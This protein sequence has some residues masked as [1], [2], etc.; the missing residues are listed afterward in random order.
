MKATEKSGISNIEAPKAGADLAPQLTSLDNGIRV[1]TQNMAH[2]ETVSLGIWVSC[3]ARH[4]KA[5][6][7]G[8]SHFLEHMA[9]KGTARRSARQIAEE[10]EQV[11]G[12]LN[13]ATSL[14]TTA[15]YAR[16]LKDDVAL[17]LD[18]LSDILNNPSY[19]GEEIERE[20]DVILQE[21]AATKD[22]PEE[23]A[24]DIVQEL[25]FTGQAIGRPILGT[26]ERVKSF[27]VEDLRRFLSL[28][29]TPER[30]IVAAAGAVEHEAIVDHV[31]NLFA[32]LDRDRGGAQQLQPAQYHGGTGY[33]DKP[34]EQSHMTMAFKAPS[35]LAPNYF[36]AQVFSALLGGGMSSRLFQEVREKR[37]LC[38]SIY[39][40]C[41]GVADAG[42][43]SINAATGPELIDELVQVI[44]GQLLRSA[45]TCPEMREVERAKAQMKAG[46]MMSLESSA[47]RAEQM[48]RH[49]FAYG[50]LRSTTEIIDQINAVT[51]GQVRQVAQD[52]LHAAQPSF[53]IVGPGACAR[54]ID[55]TTP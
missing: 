13:A 17:A 27:N 46:L 15:Y 51:P 26:A 25:A 1:V 10:I 54:T 38:Y 48:A 39:S 40:G 8:I 19:N 53:A 43:F 7:N 42:V 44:C 50:R 12:D 14:E 49:L 35:Y 32:H 23:L 31:Q 33:L 18:L 28:N 6:E 4:E 30:M 2:L 3:G 21:I 20:R 24:Y 16:V 36:A 34:F 11:G 45:D 55:F 5:S 47:V 9:F 52:L 37:G 41:W 22:S 29:Y